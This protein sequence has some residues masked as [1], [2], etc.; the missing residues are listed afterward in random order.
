MIFKSTFG[1]T[2][3]CFTFIS[4]NVSAAVVSTDWL[5]AGDNLI[6]HD[7]V[8][9]LDWLDLTETND[10]S[11][12]FV[13]GQLVT[14]GQFAGWRYAT[15]T[16]V[17]TLWNNFGINLS[18]SHPISVIGIDPGIAQATTY[19]GNIVNEFSSTTFPHG[20]LGITS[21]Q[22]ESTRHTR[23]GAYTRIDS[24]YYNDER[25]SISDDVV[26]LHTGSYLVKTSVIPVPPSVWLFGSGL[27]GL[28]GV[29]R[30]KVYV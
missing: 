4:F 22:P 16:E 2:C 26:R 12:D 10:L 19:I 17:I 30:R 28:V 24:S 27:L 8:S 11:Y 23:M 20:A 21:D 13:S 18:A 1:A 6:T 9:G 29:A 3:A 7:T 5:T 25:H 14:G 15:N